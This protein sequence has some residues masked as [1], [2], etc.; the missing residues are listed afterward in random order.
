MALYC[1]RWN[2]G[3]I[4]LPLNSR[5]WPTTQGKGIGR[6]MVHCIFLSRSG[7]TWD[8]FKDNNTT[9]TAHQQRTITSFFSFISSHAPSQ[10]RATQMGYQLGHFKGVTIRE[11]SCPKALA[12][13]TTALSPLSSIDESHYHLALELLPSPSI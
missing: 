12:I 7:D 5:S 10:S 2:K 3:E 6:S 1:F 4:P 13:W 8:S 11:L 9:K